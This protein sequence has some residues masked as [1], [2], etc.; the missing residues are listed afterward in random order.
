M[1]KEPH[2]KDIDGLPQEVLQN[3]SSRVIKRQR[4]SKGKKYTVKKI[5]PFKRM[6]MTLLL[7]GPMDLDDMVI[8]LYKK[9]GT[10]NK[11]TSV[12]QMM[13]RFLRLGY[14]EKS[15]KRMH[16]IYRLTDAGKNALEEKQNPGAE[17]W[18]RPSQKSKKTWLPKFLSPKSDH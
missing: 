6:I 1:T 3:L 14:V 16:K 10:I 2:K 4:S 12:H 5:T 11:R 9:H 15:G 7:E 17:D 18:V 13:F 8:A